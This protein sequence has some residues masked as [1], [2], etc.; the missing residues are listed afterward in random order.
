MDNFTYSVVRSFNQYIN[1]ALGTATLT[2]DGTTG[3]LMLTEYPAKIPLDRDTVGVHFYQETFE[4][5]SGGRWA[6]GSRGRFGL[7]GCQIDILSP[8]NTQGEMRAGANRKLKDAVEG[9]LKD[10]TRLNLLQWDGTGGTTVAGGMYVRQTEASFEPQN[11]L[12]GW[13]RWR[14]DYHIRAVD[15]EG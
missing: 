10:R 8:P 12:E 4:E 2:I 14:L 1:S 13:A 7:F 6:G 9:V 11:D 15:H 3:T 5:I